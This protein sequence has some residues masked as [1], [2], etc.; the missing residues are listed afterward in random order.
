MTTDGALADDGASD[1]DEATC[2]LKM[3][4]EDEAIGEFTAEQMK[5]IIDMVVESPAA[6]PQWTRL[7]ADVL[8]RIVS[9]PEAAYSGGGEICTRKLM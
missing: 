1:D 6:I 3:S 5:A 2:S 8:K 4:G 9:D 7:S